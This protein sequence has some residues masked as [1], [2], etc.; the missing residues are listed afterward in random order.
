[1]SFGLSAHV[2]DQT[3]R[4]IVG[5][6]SLLQH[7]IE[8]VAWL[9]IIHFVEAG[10]SYSLAETSTVSPTS[11]ARRSKPISMAA[12]WSKRHAA[13]VM[14]LKSSTCRIGSSH[15]RRL[16]V[17]IWRG[18]TLSGLPIMPA[19]FYLAIFVGRKSW[20][21]ICLPSGAFFA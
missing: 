2:D 4:Y 20:Q 17:Q 3:D 16:T 10:G 11:D 5:V 9:E 13:G 7:D 19:L 18:M 6:R 15:A 8:A 12:G 14:A 1:M 21:A